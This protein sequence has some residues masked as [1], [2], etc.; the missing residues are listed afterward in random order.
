MLYP[1]AKNWTGKYYQL[2]EQELIQVHAEIPDDIPPDEFLHAELFQTGIAF[3]YPS[4]LLFAKNIDTTDWTLDER[5]KVLLFEALLQVYLINNKLFKP[6]AFEKSLLGFYEAYKEERSFSVFRFFIKESPGIKLERMLSQRVHIRKTF[7]NMLWVNY[8]SNSLVFLDVLAY[9]QYLKK[10]HNLKENYSIYAETVLKTIILAT[11]SDGKVEPQEQTIFNVFIASA[12]LVQ[13]QRSEIIEA[14][15][16]GKIT[17]NDIQLPPYVDKLFN[18]FLID[19]AVLTVFSDLTAM[20]DEITFLYDLCNHLEVD[21]EILHSSLVLIE[22]FVL[23]NNHKVTFLQESSSYDRLYKS[24]S[25]RWVKV[26]GRNKDKLVEELKNNKELVSL[27]NK[28]L[29]QDLSTE[30]KEK[31]RSQFKDVVKSM[32]ALAIFMLPGGALLLPIIFKIVPDLLPSSF[33]HNE[34]TKK[35]INKKKKGK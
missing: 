26:L 12:N 21:T 15:K 19:I 17:L 35:T 1:G 20:D 18:Y 27:V 22:G 6:E 32:P 5:L 16:S 8:L 14:S 3:G 29:V 28:S 10:G 4:Q 30:E 23:E 11:F 24:F 9:R 13:P 7:T 25:K 2:I 31:V 34:L 33:K